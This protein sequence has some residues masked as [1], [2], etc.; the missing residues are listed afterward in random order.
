ML[1]TWTPQIVLFI[2]G[3]LFKTFTEAVVAI[4]KVA[5]HI[6]EMQRITEQFSPIFHQLIDEFGV[7]E[8]KQMIVERRETSI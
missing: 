7:F 6:N 3:N 2:N 4:E 8:V 1:T 5:E